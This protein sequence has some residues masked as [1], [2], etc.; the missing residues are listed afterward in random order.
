MSV[1]KLTT[2]VPTAIVK[3]GM[4][5]TQRGANL[6][7]ADF[8]DDRDK[9]RDLFTHEDFVDTQLG[10]EPV[11][12]LLAGTSR[13]L[14]TP[15]P[16]TVRAQN[17][18]KAFMSGL[19]VGNYDYTPDDMWSAEGLAWFGSMIIPFYGMYLAGAAAGG[20][21]LASIRW[22]RQTGAHGF[23][24]G[25]QVGTAAGPLKGRALSKFKAESS[26]DSRA[27]QVEDTW[28]SLVP[29]ASVE[30]GL[31]TMADPTL[32][33]PEGYAQALAF[34]T[35]G[36]AAV[37]GLGNYFRSTWPGQ[38]DYI[39]Q[40]IFTN[41]D[42]TEFAGTI[43]NL[44][45]KELPEE[46]FSVKAT[47]EDVKKY[48][49][50]TY[51]LK[52]DINSY[53]NTRKHNNETIDKV[54]K[55]I[56]DNPA[57][58]S[59]SVDEA[60]DVT[61]VTS[62]KVITTDRQL[63]GKDA[64]KVRVARGER[65]KEYYAD[66]KVL[67][68]EFKHDYA[69]TERALEGVVNDPVIAWNMNKEDLSSFITWFGDLEQQLRSP[70]ARN[71]AIKEAKAILR[72]D[73]DTVTRPYKYG[74]P[75]DILEERPRLAHILSEVIRAEDGGLFYKN[76]T[77]ELLPFW[78]SIHKLKKQLVEELTIE[79]TEH[80]KLL[81]LAGIDDELGLYHDMGAKL[82]SSDLKLTEDELREALL[83]ADITIEDLRKII[84]LD[85]TGDASRGKF[86]GDN[87]EAVMRI[88]N[89][90]LKYP[91]RDKV[92][93]RRH[94]LIEEGRPTG[95]VVTGDVAGRRTLFINEHE[96][97]AKGLLKFDKTGNLIDT[98][99]AKEIE[100]AKY[101]ISDILVEDT[102]NISKLGERGEGI[103]THIRGGEEVVRGVNYDRDIA[104]FILGDETYLTGTPGL[105][106]I[107][108]TGV[109][110]VGR[111]YHL[112]QLAYRHKGLIDFIKDEFVSVYPSGSAESVA[113]LMRQ[114][115]PESLQSTV[116]YDRIIRNGDMNPA[117]IQY[118]NK[119]PNGPGILQ[120]LHTHI[121]AEDIGKVILENFQTI[122]LAP[123]ITDASPL[124]REAARNIEKVLM[125]KEYNFDK[126]IA[127]E[128]NNVKMG[129]DPMSANTLNIHP[130]GYKVGNTK[131]PATSEQV[132]DSVIMSPGYN[133]PVIYKN[134]TYNNIEE[135]YYVW[136]SGKENKQLVEDIS[137]FA[138]ET[139]V[140]KHAY[141]GGQL[142]EL[143][144][145]GIRTQTTRGIN[146]PKY[147][148]G[149]ELISESTGLQVPIKITKVTEGY[150]PKDFAKQGYKSADEY[151][152][153]VEKSAG[154]YTTYDFKKI[155]T[156]SKLPM[157]P[158]QIKQRADALYSSK[159]WNKNT[160]KDNPD[161]LFIYG[162]NNNIRQDKRA[163]AKDGTVGTSV[164]RGNKNSS[165]IRTRAG[166]TRAPKDYIGMGMSQTAKKWID[167]DIEVIRK[168]ANKY[169]RVVV[170]P[171][172]EARPTL[173]KAS[174][175]TFGKEFDHSLSTSR[176][177]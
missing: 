119:L 175:I 114:L 37:V 162:D 12:Y 56:L 122:K 9:A 107:G 87:P 172:G 169:T 57:G 26:F 134:K 10:L 113:S 73:L 160:P 132:S 120:S 112:T 144:D 84:N 5:T 143:I 108:G 28:G 33:G 94:P 86:F 32:D 74:S 124:T 45:S 176:P 91:G 23:R 101:P 66:D 96:A 145:K 105:H 51:K 174:Q 168:A 41:K 104:R 25:G 83:D 125:S 1:S 43:D 152:K 4:G 163:Y 40:K 154:P 110:T 118:I 147:K 146:H 71:A 98:G 173:T 116:I 103:Q 177:K 63:L 142:N 148:V 158:A 127:T 48:N 65:Q 92:S 35:V 36:Q 29:Q 64:Y 24:P 130:E 85:I 60:G 140:I 137:S 90:I 27:R 22:G 106:A 52:N 70:T 2:S 3:G 100:K 14:E 76:Q 61:V 69:V 128:W 126:I 89:P 82:R 135:A 72:K 150:N 13:N 161:T 79:G 30:A 136:K 77:T 59:V 164:V 153:H 20:R 15:M 50:A 111:P 155:K 117:L 123:S 47:E 149:D 53:E 38:K 21:M 75:L 62:D 167:E 18:G 129:I 151:I 171:I 141:K 99:L 88:V 133:I 165:G 109:V 121:L 159:A 115:G 8:Q 11:S 58:P 39:K 42:T 67:S 31:W 17:I 156:A 138:V 54:T 80:P 6:T 7:A 97:L 55:D 157:T 81:G 131:Y 49:E 46:G 19:T 139:P 95:M 34:T 68:E 16:E 170:P 78:E 166:Y 102:F 93:L 44:A